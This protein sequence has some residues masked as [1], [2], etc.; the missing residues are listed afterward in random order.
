M[1][2]EARQEND[3]EKF[4]PYLEKIISYQKNYAKLIGDKDHLYNVVL[5]DYEEE[6]TVTKLC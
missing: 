3:F 5:D 6:M 1:W 4:A 2:A